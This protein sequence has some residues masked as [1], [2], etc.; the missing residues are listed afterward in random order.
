MSNVISLVWNAFAVWNV[1]AV[2]SLN[3]ISLSYL[4]YFEVIPALP[5]TVDPSNWIHTD[6]QLH[7]FLPVERRLPH[8]CR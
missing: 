5:S 2:F 7:S 8:D 3:F 4:S 1:F 6:T